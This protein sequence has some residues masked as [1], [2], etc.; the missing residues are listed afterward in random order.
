MNEKVNSV[1]GNFREIYVKIHG[2][3]G[4][5]GENC[6]ET[7]WE[8]LGNS[9]KVIES[10]WHNFYINRPNIN[11]FDKKNLQV[12]Q[13][14]TPKLLSHPHIHKMKITSTYRQPKPII[15]PLS[16][17]WHSPIH[18]HNGKFKKLYQNMYINRNWPFMWTKRI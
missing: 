14:Y 4:E 18:M 15:L 7:L 17:Q 3:A 5:I 1:P 8:T 9:W 6:R 12:R 13:H 2:N 11:L 10:W 16:L